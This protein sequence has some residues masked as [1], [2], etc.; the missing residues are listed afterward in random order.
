MNFEESTM[1]AVLFLKLVILY[2]YVGNTKIYVCS[3][4]ILLLF[5]DQVSGFVNRIWIYGQ[6]FLTF[7]KRKNF[8]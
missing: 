8:F 3:Q 4:D 6:M 7:H 5:V 1:V 2:M